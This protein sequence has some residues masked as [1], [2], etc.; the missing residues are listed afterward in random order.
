M[1]RYNPKIS[2][3]T[4]GDIPSISVV[5]GGSD[6]VI[7]FLHGLD[8]SKESDF[9]FHLAAAEAGFRVVAPD[10]PGYGERYVVPRRSSIELIKE[11]FQTAAREVSAVAAAV[12]AEGAASVVLAGRSFGGMRA[13][14]A[15]DSALFDGLLL[16]NTGGDF[17]TLIE[18]SC[19]SA[20]QAPDF[21]GNLSPEALGEF[22][23]FDPV[24]TSSR[25]P[26]MPVWL[27]IDRNDEII[28][29]DCGK[30]LADELNG[31]K[32]FILR[33]YTGG[34]HALTDSIIQDGVEW[35]SSF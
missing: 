27:G 30:S 34:G 23:Q 29:F 20:L 33:E 15:A 22:A 5:N 32:D 8:A 17:E 18:R 26:E 12:R 14:F 10:A 19:S 6:R 21:R 24:R 7:I 9:R 28:P 31:R 35:L 13:V 2:F 3:F 1:I 11:G 25:I 16:M 4:I